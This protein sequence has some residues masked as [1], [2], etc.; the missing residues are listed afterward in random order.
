MNYLKDYFITNDYL[1]KTLNSEDVDELT[2]EAPDKIVISVPS[3][4][5]TGSIGVG[6]VTSIIFF[7]LSQF[8]W[9]VVY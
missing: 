9:L 1:P 3:I 6:P 5:A 4:C 8:V 2:G 7:V